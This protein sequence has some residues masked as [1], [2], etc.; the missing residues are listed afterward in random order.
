LR[1]IDE[2]IWQIP[3]GLRYRLME[4]GRVVTLTRGWAVYGILANDDNP[5]DHAYTV[6]E[7]AA[8]LDLSTEDASA[9]MD[10]CDNSAG[11]DRGLRARILAACGLTVPTAF[12]VKDSGQRQDFATGARRDTDAGKVRYALIRQLF[13]KRTAARLTGG[14][15]KYGEGNWEKGMPFSRTVDSLKRHVAEWIDGDASEDH[16][17]AA[18]CN[19]MFL[20]CWEDWIRAGRLA[21][22]LDDRETLR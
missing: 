4:T 6:A 20:M 16:L 8:G 14:A 13:T 17:A 21:P 12:G 10:A 3:S 22:D 11:C 5:A 18:A 19:L 2:V 9:F 15:V 1:T 7:V